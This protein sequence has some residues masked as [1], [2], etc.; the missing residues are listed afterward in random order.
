MPEPLQAHS[1]NEA[2]YYL[3]VTPCPSCGKGPWVLDAPTADGD[4]AAFKGRCS[5]CETEQEFRFRCGPSDAGDDETIN[6]TD[7]SSEIVDLAQWISLFYA[8]IESAARTQSRPEARRLGYRAALC[9]AEA[10]KFYGDDELPPASAFFTDAT[11]EAFREHPE[12]FARQRLRDMR[13]KLPSMGTMARRVR[14]DEKPRRRW[15][16]FWR[17]R[18]ASGQYLSIRCV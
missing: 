18:G 12:R 15:W 9:L 3:R 1:V 14:S 13:S 2:R 11:A 5:H 17:R 4:E 10:L 7:R 8:L 16:Q 6:P